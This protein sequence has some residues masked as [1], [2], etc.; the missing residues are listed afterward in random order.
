MEN[1]I[2]RAFEVPVAVKIFNSSHFLTEKF[3]FNSLVKD[4]YFNFLLHK[5]RS[6]KLIASLSNFKFYYNIE[7]LVNDIRDEF[8]KTRHATGSINL[9]QD[10]I[11]SFLIPNVKTYQTVLRGK[12]AKLS[13][14]QNYIF[15]EMHQ[16]VPILNSNEEVIHSAANT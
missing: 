15:P 12:T 7:I 10:V 14:A 8:K 16:G 11:S 3:F 9:I 2:Q 1:L 6:K 4:Y 5:L 13:R